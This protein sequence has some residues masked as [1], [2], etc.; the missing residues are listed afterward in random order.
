MQNHKDEFSRTR[1]ARQIHKLSLAFTRDPA[2]YRL[3]KFQISQVQL[4]TTVSKVI[5]PTKG[6]R[7]S[8]FTA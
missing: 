8:G 3:V 7:K 1:T 5:K 6:S 4:P 2:L